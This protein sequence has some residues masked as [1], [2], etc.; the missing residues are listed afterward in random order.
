[1]AIQTTLGVAYAVAEAEP[2]TRD[3]AGFAALTWI[4][5]SETTELGE[6]GPTFEVVEAKTLESGITRKRK[7]TGNYGSLPI[8]MLL[9]SG[10][11]GQLSMESGAGGA[12]RD[13]VY[14]HRITYQ[15]GSIDYQTGQIFSFVKT[16]ASADEFVTAQA[17]VEFEEPAVFVAA[18]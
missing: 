7:G 2:A 15:D 5:V 8:N 3:S 16:V 1:M 10:D 17:L 11:A 6:S 13:Q 12:N 18:P 9:D 4:E 14:S